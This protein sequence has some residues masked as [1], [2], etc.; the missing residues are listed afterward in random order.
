MGKNKQ[1]ARDYFS[2]EV[3]FSCPLLLVSSLYLFL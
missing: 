1:G 3:L 2:N